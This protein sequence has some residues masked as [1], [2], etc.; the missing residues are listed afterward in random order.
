MVMDDNVLFPEIVKITAGHYS[1]RGMI[2]ASMKSNIFSSRAPVERRRFIVFASF[3]G[4]CGFDSIL[5][6]LVM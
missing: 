4:D 3:I 1:I 6:M 5:G 2:S